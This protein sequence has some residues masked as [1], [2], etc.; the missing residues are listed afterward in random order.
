[1]GWGEERGKGE[2]PWYA[3]YRIGTLPNGRPKVKK[4][5][6]F[7][8]EDAAKKHALDQEADIRRGRWH[9]RSRGDL[10]LDD[11]FYKKWLPVQKVSQDS[12]DRRTSEYRTH[13]SP[14]WG[15]GTL[16]EIDPFDVLAFEIELYTKLS[17]STAGNVMGLLRQM[18]DLAVFGKLLDRSPMMPREMRTAT[19]PDDTRPGMVATLDEVF[20]IADRLPAA[21][22]LMTLTAV[23]SGMRWGEVAGMR[24]RFLTLRPATE[25]ESASGHYVID[26]KVGALK[27]KR[28]GTRYFGPPKGG[29]GR[30]VELP[31]FLVEVLIR[32]IASLDK[33]RDLVFANR[34][35]GS[36]GH[37]HVINDYW[38]PACD[39]WPARPP[40]RRGHGWREAVPAADP[41]RTGLRFHDLRHTHKTWLA[42]DG[43]EPRARDER[44]GHESEGMDAVY[45]HPTDKMR[46]AIL[47]ALEDRWNQALLTLPTPKWLPIPVGTAGQR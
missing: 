33:G 35:G 29:K 41:I 47:A 22:A 6:G 39:G 32:H 14:R 36:W 24:R 26:P 12:K 31:S 44:L 5:P 40:A 43:I 42:D 18:M 17:N 30:T 16:N 10:T 7:A 1:M 19:R 20:S 2:Y 45:I 21:L 11:Y 27:E 13:I 34:R 9:D 3:C 25:N 46:A 23:F 4:E 8:T 28:S 37:S 15:T 38:R